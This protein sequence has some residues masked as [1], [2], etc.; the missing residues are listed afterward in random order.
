ML[1]A[2]TIFKDE[3]HG[4][5]VIAAI[6]EVQL[7]ASTMARRVSSLSEKLTEQLDRDLATCGWFSIQC[8]E[9]VDSASTA[10]LMVFIRDSLRIEVSNYSP[11]YNTLVSRMQ[12][13]ASHLHSK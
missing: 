7:G 13:Q 11:D 2:N 1:V 3:K 4:P 10:H 8:D 5:D 9:S 12:C 6:S